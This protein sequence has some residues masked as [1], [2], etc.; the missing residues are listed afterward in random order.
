MSFS[1]QE[2]QILLIVSCTEVHKTQHP[3]VHVTAKSTSFRRSC[4]QETLDSKGT[5]LRTCCPQAGREA[6]HKLPAGSS[7]SVTEDGG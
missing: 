7:T 3:E 5:L 1:D 4:I 6:G 2:I